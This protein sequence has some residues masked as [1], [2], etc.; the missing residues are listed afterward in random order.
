MGEG[1]GGQGQGETLATP[2]ATGGSVALFRDS[3]VAID[4]DRVLLITE[5]DSNVALGAGMNH[6]LTRTRENAPLVE[7]QFQYKGIALIVQFR[8]HNLSLL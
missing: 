5:S 4:A 7:G 1:W 2:R 6:A 3:G 8:F